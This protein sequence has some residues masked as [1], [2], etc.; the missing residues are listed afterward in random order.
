MSKFL[1]IMIVLLTIAAVAAPVM[2]E[3]R[4]G[5]SGQMRV[6][7]WHIDNENDLGDN[8][9][10]FFDQRLRIGG[11]FSIADGVSVT[12]RTDITES[13]WGT[14]GGGNGFG[15]GRSGYDG[16]N[17]WDR[18][19]LDIAFD[20]FSL[21]AGQQYVEFGAGATISSQDNGFKVVSGPVT[22]FFLLDDNNGSTTTTSDDY[23][24]GANYGYKADGYKANLFVA[25]QKGDGEEVYL[26]GADTTF[27]LDAVKIVAELDFFTG[28]ASDTVDA[29]GTQL[30]VDASMAASET[31]TFGGQLFYALGDEDDMQYVVLGNDFGGWDPL[32]DVGTGLDNEKIGAG[33]PYDVFDDNAGVIAGRLYT[34]VKASDAATFGASVLYAVPEEDAN[35]PDVDSALGLAAGLSY[36]LMAN[37]KLDVQVEYIDVDAPGAESVMQ[38]GFGLFV[39][40]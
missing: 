35:V 40:F 2:A 19:H 3:D 1:K 38:G 23:L 28:D 37:T 17:Q 27:N 33:R 24:Y 29:F 7:G 4:L 9:N 39:N 5:L 11:K 34:S 25:S 13:T 32:F 26:I 12:F 22:A 10:S 31:M 36:K 20:S 30:M 8:T 15:S 21:R 14:T 18:A 6:R 16:S